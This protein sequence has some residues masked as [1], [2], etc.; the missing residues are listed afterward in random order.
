MGYWSFQRLA[1]SKIFYFFSPTCFLCFK[2]SP[3]I[4][5]LS[6]KLLQLCPAAKLQK[7]LVDCKTSFY[8][9][10]HGSERTMTLYITL[11]FVAVY[12]SY[13]L[14]MKGTLQIK[15]YHLGWHTG[16]LY[17]N[18]WSAVPLHK[19]KITR[20][21]ARS[22][23]VQIVLLP[24]LDQHCWVGKLEVFTRLHIGSLHVS[25][26]TFLVSENPNFLNTCTA[27][28]TE[29]F[30]F[31]RMGFCLHGGTFYLRASAT[32]H[33]DPAGMWITVC[34]GTGTLLNL[35]WVEFWEV[36]K[37]S[38]ISLTEAAQRVTK[39]CWEVVGLMTRGDSANTVA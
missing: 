22:Y 8:F 5:L 2:T 20:S 18:G 36:R 11:K 37:S 3:H 6:T 14:C 7:W 32:E 29:G 1:W 31:G 15:S 34:A 26:N 38:R 28:Y 4:L 19:T 9:H 10:Q 24:H 23:R 35:L 30:K 25:V 27:A 12:M 16:S 33:E 17:S 21:D 39:V 13:N